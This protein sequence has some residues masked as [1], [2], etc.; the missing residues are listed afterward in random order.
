[1]IIMEDSEIMMHIE[2]I[3]IEGS[4]ICILFIYYC[5]DPLGVD[6]PG[7]SRLEQEVISGEGDGA[8]R[9][10]VQNLP[11]GGHGVGLGV[12][13]DLRQGV[14]QLHVQLCEAAHAADGLHPLLQ[15]VPCRHAGLLRSLPRSSKAHSFRRSLAHNPDEWNGRRRKE[16]RRGDSPC[17]QRLW[18]SRWPPCRT[19]QTWASLSPASSWKDQALR[20]NGWG[21]RER[22]GRGVDD[23]GTGSGVG[24]LALGSPMF[25]HATTPPLITISGL[26]PK[27]EGFH[28]TRSASF[29]AWSR[30]STD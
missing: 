19:R 4:H 17:S 29:P 5:S 18:S 7:S 21:E 6:P 2:I 10:A 16:G 15:A 1:M 24:M 11:V 3:I 27:K 26:A 9:G 28:M 30:C 8:H 25:A 14:V 20:N 22:G 23:G 12:D 13:L